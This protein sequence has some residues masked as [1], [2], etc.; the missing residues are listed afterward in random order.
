MLAGTLL[1]TRNAYI[2]RH[3]DEP[4]DGDDEA[5]VCAYGGLK[6]VDSQNVIGSKIRN[7][8][9]GNVRARL[10]AVTILLTNG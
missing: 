9:M 1:P 6:P 2:Y 8:L 5:F 3:T 4:G 7:F 10:A